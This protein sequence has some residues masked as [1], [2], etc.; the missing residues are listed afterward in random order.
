LLAELKAGNPQRPVLLITARGSI[1]MAVEA[2][3]SGAR[4][5]LTKPI[6]DFQKLKV[7]L[8][9]AERDIELRRKTRK[10]ADRAE[11]DGVLGDMVGSTK[12]M[13]AVFSLIEMVAGRDVPVIITG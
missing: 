4:D 7:L 2:I 6:T 9:D 11:G 12:P 13:R 1:D 10:L 5:F 8:E 3:K